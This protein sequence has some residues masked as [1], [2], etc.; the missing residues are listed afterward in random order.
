VLNAEGDFV[1]FDVV[2]GNPP[3]MRVQEIQ[4]TQPKQKEHY[5][6]Q[7]QNASAAY[8]LANIF[9]ELAVNISSLESNNAYIFPHKFFNSASSQ[10]FRKYLKEG[11]F[12]DEIAHFGANMVFDD[13]DTYTCVA[14]FSKRASDGFHFQRFPLNSEYKELMLERSKYGYITYEMIDRASILYGSNQWILF[15]NEIGFNVFE[16]IYDGSRLFSEIFEGIFQGLATSKDDLYVVECINE[17][18]FTIQ[19]PI[20]GK[21][22]KVERDLFKPF[23]KGRD[24]QR[25]VY[26]STDKYVF[27]PYE[28]IGD[29]SKILSVKDIQKK[30]PKTYEYVKDHE[31]F[32]KSRESGK[33]AK[34][35]HWHVYIYP[36]NLNKFDQPKLSSMEICSTKPNVAYNQRNF[37]HA[38]T[39]YSWIK[40]ADTKESYEYLLSI[41]NSKLLWW[42]LKTTG[43]TLRGDARRFKTNYLNPFPMP[44]TVAPETE[45]SISDR[46]KKVMS[47]KKQDPSADTSALEAEI[48]GLVYDLYGLTDEEVGVVEGAG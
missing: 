11:Q 16:K 37:Y 32:F 18:E 10:V 43:D 3:Y 30:Y 46:V 1:G 31:K 44:Q 41:A 8:D 13:A 14:Q 12:I 20:S 24:V 25:Y 48:D 4:K 47:L 38:T 42:F 6:T 45:K 40:S 27:F 5:E 39:V 9:F 33:A 17:D 19:V 28:V 2:I 35:E 15:D 29:E 21:K 7:Y 36:K 23:L 22:Y 26:L 34:M